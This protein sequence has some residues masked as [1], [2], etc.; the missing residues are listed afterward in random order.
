[1]V[2][3]MLTGSFHHSLISIGQYTI[4]VAGWLRPSS[5]SFPTTPM[6]SRQGFSW[7]CLTRLPRASAGFFQCSRAKFS[8]VTTTGLP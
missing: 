7:F 6:I 4:A 8:D 2:L 1:M 5:R 3:P